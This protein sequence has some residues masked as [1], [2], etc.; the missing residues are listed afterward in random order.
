MRFVVPTSTSLAPD[1]ASTSGMRKP[2]PIS[3]SSPRET[4]TSRPSASA[5]SASRTQPRC[6]SRRAQPRRPSAGRGAPRRDPGASRA[7]RVEVVLEI[8]VAA[9][10]LDDTRSSAAAGSGARPRFVCTITP[11][12]LRTRR[13]VGRRAEASSR[14]S[15]RARSPGSPPARICSRA[16]S[17]T[18]RAASTASGSSDARA[19][20]STEGRSRELHGG[21]WASSLKAVGIVA[22]RRS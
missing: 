20:S 8:R 12:A 18:A 4:S 15:A 14:A 17:I 22:Q 9:R 2:S 11:V 6:C 3:I 19:S 7:R 16:R 10:D 21:Y 13:R 5:A 1:R